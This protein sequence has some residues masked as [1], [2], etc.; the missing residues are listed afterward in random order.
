[1]ITDTEN[2]NEALTAHSWW[3][4]GGHKRCTVCGVR[5]DQAKPGPCKSFRPI[6]RITIPNESE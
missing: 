4:I 6:G 3:Q 1:M 2:R 5:E